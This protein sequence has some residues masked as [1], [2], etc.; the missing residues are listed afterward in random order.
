MYSCLTVSAN[1][2]GPNVDT[3][4]RALKLVRLRDTCILIVY[5]YIYIFFTYVRWKEISVLSNWK[6][7]QS[8]LRWCLQTRWS[9]N[10]S[11]FWNK[12]FIRI[13]KFYNYRKLCITIFKFI[14]RKKFHC[15]ELAKSYYKFILRW[16]VYNV[17]SMIYHR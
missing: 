7:R 11:F 10:V 4:L 5:I 1:S 9:N 6:L 14:H 17:F 16:K 3:L 8:H 12:R 15:D 13:I 2:H